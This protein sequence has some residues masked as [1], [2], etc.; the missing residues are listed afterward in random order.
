M[1][2]VSRPYLV[3]SFLFWLL[4]GAFGVYFLLNIKRF[5]N[6]GIDL[7][8]G[9]YLTLSVRY[10]EAFKE[11]LLSIYDDIKQDLKEKSAVLPVKSKLSENNSSILLEF[12]SKEN[13]ISALDLI[14]SKTQSRYYNIGKDILI[15]IDGKFLNVYLSNCFANKIK[16][17]AIE[18]D[19]SVIRTRLDS[20]GLGEISI[21]PQGDNDIVVE[22]PISDN[23]EKIK[24]RIGK[25]A[26]LQM[27]PVFRSA[28]LKESLLKSISNKIPDGMMILESRPDEKGNREYYLVPMNPALTGKLLKDVSV[29][30]DSIN[31]PRDFSSNSGTNIRLRFNSQGATK[32]YDLTSKNIGERVAII[33]DDVVIAAPQ[34]STA[35]PGGE[36]SISGYEKESAQELVYLLKSG[37]FSAP[38]DFVEERQIGPSLGQES[39]HKGLLACAVGLALLFIFSIFIY[40]TAGLFAFI[41]LLY[42]LLFILYGL[43]YIPDAVLTLPG[44]AGMVLTLGM[45]IDSSILIYERI[46]ED[47]DLKIPLAQAVDNGFSGA[48]TVILDANIT[49]FIVGAVLYYFGSPAIQG[50]ALT[51]MIGIVST[52]LTGLVL[53]KVIFNFFIYVLNFKKI[54]F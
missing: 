5:V 50:F 28:Y 39:I 30:D 42:N 6:L 3:I 44:I 19:I 25:S 21:L 54:S 52:L 46:K 41:V 26:V 48:T 1:T 9:T 14:K 34:V 4:A 43:A 27:K 31:A 8:G 33:I 32:F 36:A 16:Q 45:A 49:T 12:D 10:Q 38:V 29:A 7:Q 18:S 53:L 15:N 23:P 17:D 47:L 40:K 11:E 51:M 35:I 13:A 20:S 24:E 22:L 37:S 2:L